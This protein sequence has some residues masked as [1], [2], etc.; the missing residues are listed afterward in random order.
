MTG[1]GDELPT[2]VLDEPEMATAA[3]GEAELPTFIADGAT[4]TVPAPIRPRPVGGLAIGLILWGII[5]GLVV[6]L[7]VML[8]M[9]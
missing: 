9:E 4:M 5:A 7:V 8:L 3:L 2:S 6:A 1:P